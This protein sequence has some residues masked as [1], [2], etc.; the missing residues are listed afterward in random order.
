MGSR[1]SLSRILLPA[2]ASAALDAATKQ[3]VDGKQASDSDL[4]SIATLAPANDDVIQ[5]KSGVWVNRTMAQLRTDLAVQPLDTDLTTIASLTAATDSFM[6]AKVGAWA[7]RTIAQ[8]KTDLGISNVT[9]TSDPNKPVSTAQLASDLAVFN[10][11]RVVSGFATSDH[12]ITQATA[13]IGGASV[14]F[15]TTTANA[16]AVVTCN[17]DFRLTVLGTGYCYGEFAVDGTT[18]AKKALFVF[19]N[20]ET[21]EPGS[22]TMPVTLASTGSHTIKLRC[23]KDA[24]DGTGTAYMTGDSITGLVVTI[25]DRTF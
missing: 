15:S 18:H 8:V 17:F 3:V 1:A 12:T 5:R 20:V 6:Q 4:T 13:D 22:F 2:D 21:R 16:T 11:I 7:A 25:F 9:N 10:S 19:Q 23:H 24:A 14:T